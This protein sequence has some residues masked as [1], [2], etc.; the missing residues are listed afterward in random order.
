MTQEQKIRPSSFESNFHRELSVEQGITSHY[1]YRFAEN[2]ISEAKPG[3][4]LIVRNNPT[5][6]GYNDYFGFLKTSPFEFTPLWG[7]EA[8]GT[9][10]IR[11]K[12]PH[13][14]LLHD[15]KLHLMLSAQQRRYKGEEVKSLNIRDI[16]NFDLSLDIGYTS[17]AV[18]SP[19]KEEFPTLQLLQSECHNMHILSLISTVWMYLF[20]GGLVSYTIFKYASNGISS[21]EIPVLFGASVAEVGFIRAHDYF[22]KRADKAYAEIEKMLTEKIP[23]MKDYFPQ[24]K[25]K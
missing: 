1:E 22:N 17:I 2:H 4:V 15:P 23:Q 25:E 9:D 14:K 21:A 13:E 20:G 6:S 19:K 10:E 16:H 5:D 11:P 7:L 12:W 3:D 24:Q 8:R 18:H